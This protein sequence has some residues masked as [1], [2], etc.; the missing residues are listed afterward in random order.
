MLRDSHTGTSQG[1][2]AWKRHLYVLYVTSAL[3]L[4]RSIFRVVEYLQ[5]N[6]GYLIS[7]EVFIYVMDALLMAI[8]MVIFAVWYICDLQPNK[9]SDDA[10][11]L[12][13]NTNYPM[14]EAR[15]HSKSDGGNSPC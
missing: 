10:S 5:G 7:H 13:S 6:N 14:T 8:V 1:P 12:S 15:D 3:I 11:G 2:V 4:I 9:T